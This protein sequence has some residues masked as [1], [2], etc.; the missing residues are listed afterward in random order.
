MGNKKRREAN[1]EKRRKRWGM[2]K[3][4]IYEPD[5]YDLMDNPIS[6]PDPDMKK[7]KEAIALMVKEKR[8][9]IEMPT[10]DDAT[11]SQVMCHFLNGIPYGDPPK[12]DEPPLVASPEDV[13]NAARAIRG[14]RNIKNGKGTGKFVVL[15][16]EVY[17]WTVEL[18]KEHSERV[19]NGAF[20]AI[21]IER[22]NDLYE[23][24]PDLDGIANEESTEKSK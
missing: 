8:Q 13:M 6:I 18:V 4:I 14:F 9:S 23:T 20:P 24:K 3:Y 1:E 17:K 2:D 12:K 22:I 15:E 11:Y 21:L 19:F 5:I 16:E 7:R 10:I